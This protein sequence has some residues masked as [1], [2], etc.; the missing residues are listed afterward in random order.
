MSILNKRLQNYTS[1]LI[2]IKIF[3]LNRIN[4]I[5]IYIIYISLIAR[6]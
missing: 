3:W 1:I 5:P 6:F 2:E 4:D